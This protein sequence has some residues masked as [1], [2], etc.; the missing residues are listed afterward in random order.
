[1]SQLASTMGMNSSTIFVWQ[2]QYRVGFPTVDRQHEHLLEMLGR[3]QEAMREGKGKEA[4]KDILQELA[5]YTRTHF[6][7]EE[8]YFNRY[9]YPEKEEH[10]R[11]H[12]EFVARVAQFQ[13]DF[14]QGK[15]MLSVALLNWLGDWIRNH[16]LKVDKKAFLFLKERG[17]T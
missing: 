16:I 10:K 11:I 12:D 9:E 1:M 2:E 6:G 8:A 14:A 4:L 15:A 3:L 17:A 7:T 5:G 13:S